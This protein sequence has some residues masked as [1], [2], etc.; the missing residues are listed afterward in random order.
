MRRFRVDFTRP[1]DTHHF[2]Q[3]NQDGTRTYQHVVPSDCKAV[4]VVW[5]DKTI[6]V[7]WLAP[8]GELHRQEE[9][10]SIEEIRALNDGKTEIRWEDPICFA[11]GGTLDFNEMHARHCYG[12]GAGQGK[13]MH[14]EDKPN[15]SLGSWKPALI[16]GGEG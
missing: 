4:G 13:E 15:P 1:E 14:F 2:I 8:R 11:C 6:T 7:K 9:F 5:Y 3:E 16:I 12:C 10:G